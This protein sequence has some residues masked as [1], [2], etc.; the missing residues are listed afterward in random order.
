MDTA[1][2][3]LISHTLLWAVPIPPQPEEETSATFNHSHISSWA[4]GAAVPTVQQNRE[5]DKKNGPQITIN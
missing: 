1:A 2:I 4:L 3:A 5:N